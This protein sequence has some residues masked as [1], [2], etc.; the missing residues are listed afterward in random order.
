M[1]KTSLTYKFTVSYIT[2][3][4]DY[5]YITHLH[6]SLVSTSKLEQQTLQC[7]RH[8]QRWM[9]YVKVKIKVSFL[10]PAMIQF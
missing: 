5:Y 10:E 8:T 1:A 9:N 4:A 2:M 3:S 7:H 6:T